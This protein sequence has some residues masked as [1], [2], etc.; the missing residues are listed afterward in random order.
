MDA[1][2]LIFDCD[3]TLADSMPAHYEA[4]CETLSNYG[5]TLSRERFFALGGI[6]T[7]RIVEL[8]SR[9]QGVAVEADQVARERDEAFCRLA[10]RVR[11]IEP[12]VEAA[13]AHRGK[14]PMA[15]ATGGVRRQA[16]T[17]LR[18]IGIRHWFDAIITAEDVDRPKPAPDPFLKAAWALG[19]EPARCVAYE[20]TEA[21]LTSA[22]AA[23]MVVVDARLFEQPLR[24]AIPECLSASR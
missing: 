20:D 6:P 15:V 21:G 2:A 5:L 11:R 23:G 10:D 9:E 3:G 13:R 1:E 22:R 8:L 19:V 17:V 4:W 14:L 12:A 16:E 24:S 7:R 18:A